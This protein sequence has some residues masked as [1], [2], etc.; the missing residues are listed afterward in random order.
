MAIPTLFQ[1]V[2]HEGRY[3]ID[4]ALSNPLPISVALEMKA[5]KTIAVNV[6]PN[7]QKITWQTKNRKTEEVSILS[8]KLHEM[9]SNLLNENKQNTSKSEVIVDSVESSLSRIFHPTLMHVFLQSISITT[10]NLITQHLRLAKPDVLISPGIENF[11]MFE[12][13]NGIEIIKCGYDE[14]IKSLPH[15]LSLSKS[16]SGLKISNI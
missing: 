6:S 3:L 2:L 15:L 11:D 10:N 9:F 14:A 4:G 5:H 12:F 13:Y 8:K 1:P 16:P 7:P